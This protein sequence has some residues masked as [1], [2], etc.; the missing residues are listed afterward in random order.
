MIVKAPKSN[1]FQHCIIRRLKWH[2]LGPPM[3]FLIILKT[4]I[5]NKNAILFI[6]ILPHVYCHSTNCIICLRFSRYSKSWCFSQNVTHVSNPF[7]ECFL[8]KDETILFQIAK[9]LMKLQS[10]FGIIP[11]ITEFNGK[12][13]LAEHVSNILFRMRRE[14]TGLVSLLE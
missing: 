9:G 8:L 4:E 5:F 7:Q 6:I 11:H 13:A 3:K 12:E 1:E 14:M 2:F 10:L